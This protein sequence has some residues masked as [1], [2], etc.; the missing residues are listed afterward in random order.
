MHEWER[1]ARGAD[2]R[3]YP[4]GD[5]LR[6]G[7]ANFDRTYE[8]QPAA[9]GPDEVGSHPASDSPFGISDLSGNVWEWTFLANE[10]QTAYYSGG[11][12][13]QDVVTARSS[14]HVTG[15]ATQRS[16]VVGLRICA[17]L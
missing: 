8:Q 9:Y 1:A 10:P 17:D 3:R 12:F 16:V 15:E 2:S 7:D 5:V 4:H 14:N 13:Y 11:S 6:P